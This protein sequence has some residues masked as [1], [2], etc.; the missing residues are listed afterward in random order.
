MENQLMTLTD[1]VAALKTANAAAADEQIAFLTDIA[2]RLDAIG[3]GQSAD[4]QAVT[5]DITARTQALTD[6][7]A[8]VDAGGDG[9]TPVPPVDGTPVDGSTPTA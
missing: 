9:T 8:S 3:G 4:I 2:A 6:A 5:A 1:D 7:Q